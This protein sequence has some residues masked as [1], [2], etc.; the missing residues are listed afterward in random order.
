MVYLTHMRALPLAA[1]MLLPI[2]PAHAADSI[3]NPL[4]KDIDGKDTLP[5]ALSRQSPARGKRQASKCGFTPQYTALEALY[6]KY[7][8]CGS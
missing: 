1:I 8:N 7:N 2:I 6:Q 3:Y 4:V 5:Q